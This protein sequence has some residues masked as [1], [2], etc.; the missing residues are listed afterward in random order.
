MREHNG[1]CLLS[2]LR[3]VLRITAFCMLA[4][5][6]RL[7][8]D[9][10]VSGNGIEEVSEI[11]LHQSISELRWLIICW[12]TQTLNE[13]QAWFNISL[14]KEP[15][16]QA[17][18]WWIL[19][20]ELG[21]GFI[22]GGEDWR[23]KYPIESEG[24]ALIRCLWATVPLKLILF[25]KLYYNDRYSWHKTILSTYHHGLREWPNPANPWIW[26]CVCNPNPTIFW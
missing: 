17:Y 16:N 23:M 2:F 15:L 6:V 13:L 20:W 26:V 8:T 5:R 3:V 11:F 25:C 21:R 9:K 1:I 24:S 22:E 7:G 4:V 12:Y 18:Q 10:G 14:L 19:D